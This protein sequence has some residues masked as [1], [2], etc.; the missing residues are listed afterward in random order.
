MNSPRLADIHIFRRGT[1][2][3]VSGATID[4]NDEMLADAAA[5]YDPALHEAPIVVGHPEINAPAYGWVGGLS[6]AGGD[7]SAHPSQI[8][9]A[10]AEMVRNGNFKKVSASWYLPDSPVNPKPG[11]LYLRHVGFLGAAAPSVKG[12]KQAEFAADDKDIVEV[13][14]AE[15]G[16]DVEERLWQKFMGWL[17][18]RIDRDSQ[19]AFAELSTAAWSGDASKYKDA[20]AYCAACLVDT[21]EPDK[22]KV[23][24][25]CHLPVR[26]PGGAVNRHALMAAQG[27]LVGARGGVKL[28]DSVKRAA[29]KKLAG[30]MKANGIT[31]AASLTKLAD[32]SETPHEDFTVEKTPEQLQAEF[33]ERE[34]ALKAREDA[35]AA[36]EKKARDKNCAD[37]VEQLVSDG[38]V[39]P[40]DQAPLTAL[41][42]SFAADT[43]VE[44]AEEGTQIKKPAAEWLRGFLQQLPEAVDYTERAAATDDVQHVSVVNFAAPPGAKVDPAGAKLHNK[45]LAYQAKH[46]DCDYITA[47]RAVGG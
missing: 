9:P 34:T 13:E 12:L 14:F 18:A 28:P 46:K 19:T 42:A 35:L 16:S 6:F 26:E 4:F 40:R 2:T 45:A 20:A 38:K 3:A 31:P 8:D 24:A 41:L 11:H 47:V 21:N 22:T 25:M 37:F 7:V 30:L 43:Q 27:A 1:H 32:F 39:L 15:G 17:G 10:F 5:V 23:Q 33:A 36:S 44:F 29:A